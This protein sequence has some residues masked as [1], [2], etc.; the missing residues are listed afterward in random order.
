MIMMVLM[1]LSSL[2]MAENYMEEYDDLNSMIRRMRKIVI[3]M[4]RKKEEE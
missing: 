1:I 4:I 3:I 2:I